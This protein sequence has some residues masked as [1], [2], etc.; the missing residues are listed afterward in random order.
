MCTYYHNLLYLRMAPK[1]TL[2][3]HLPQAFHNFHHKPQRIILLE[4]H[5]TGLKNLESKTSNKRSVFLVILLLVV[6]NEMMGWE[7]GRQMIVVSATK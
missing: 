1:R 2:Q 6:C 4:I 7:L 5:Q 3:L